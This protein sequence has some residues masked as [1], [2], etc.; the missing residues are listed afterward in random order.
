MNLPLRELSTYD[1]EKRGSAK[2]WGTPTQQDS[3]T[4]TDFHVVFYHLP[5][6]FLRQLSEFP[7]HLIS[8]FRS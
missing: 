6:H 5:D 8:V 1:D 4:W 3:W 7:N 2:I